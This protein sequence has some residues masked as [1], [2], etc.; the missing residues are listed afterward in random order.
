MNKTAIKSLEFDKI[1]ERLASYAMSDQAKQQVKQLTPIFD[2][3]R[4]GILQNE[5]TEAC[6]IIEKSSSIPIQSLQGIEQVI[7][8]VE[9]GY[10]LTAEQLGNLA[11]F[12]DGTK[13]L[14][15][16]MKNQEFIA[17][18]IYSYAFSLSELLDLAGELSRCIRNNR[19]DDYAS[20]SLTRARKKIGV[21]EDKIKAKLQQVMKSSSGILQEQIV[22]MRNGRYV[23]PIKSEYK[24]KLAGTILDQSSSGLTVYIEPEDIRKLQDELSFLQA[25]EEIEVQKILGT[26]TEMTETYKR[27]LS[28]NMETMVAYDFIFAK[29]KLSRSM[30]GCKV[31]INQDQV[32]KIID[33]K[34]PLL[35]KNAVPLSLNLGE[36]QR[37]LVITGPNTGGKT[38]AIKTVGLLAMMVQSGLHIP[39]CKTSSFPVL[40][41][42]FVDIGDNQ[43]IEQSLSTFSS[44]IKNMISILS[45]AKIDTLVIVDEI[46]SGTDPREGMGLAISILEDL[47]KSG[48]LTIATTHYSEIKEYAEKT[49]GFQNGSMDFDVNTLQPLYR[50]L[51]GQGGS[52]QAFLIALKLGMNQDLI[53]RAYEL[54]YKASMPLIPVELL[55]KN[56][57]EELSQSEQHLR[58]M[59]ELKKYKKR[60]RIS[61]EQ[62]VQETYQLGDLVW[63]PYLNAKAI[64]C[65]LE[66]EQGELEILRNNQKE[67]VNKKRI[68]PFIDAKNLYPEEY[69][70][71]NVFETKENR[72][73]Q[74]L[75]GK[76]H[77]EGLVIERD[78]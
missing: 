59:S 41:D 9:K 75:L 11:L 49:V 38:V 67:R 10:I 12:L 61:V 63:I 57:E 32:F 62:Q 60:D 51:I 37:S 14:K 26:L 24:R 18:T 15:A 72:K 31:E 68:Q 4:I 50:L 65:S 70:L 78:E 33:A 5:T 40:A 39:A 17:P 22:S 45:L 44:H 27:E 53:R 52:S 2:R 3:K 77:V 56:G 76:K 35:G 48:G 16:F 46:G 13:K 69:D 58:N 30:D 54:T 36:A 43:S 21:L 55:Q 29:A 66:N 20:K 28:I 42:I 47:Y 34:H 8:L 7:Q 1:I 74:K 25:E 23:V 73:K 64:I 71:A 19:V 6:S